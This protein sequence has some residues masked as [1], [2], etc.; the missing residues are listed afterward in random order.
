MRPAD[1]ARLSWVLAEAGA[2]LAR[3]TA[4]DPQAPRPAWRRMGGLLR[5]GGA[6]R[7]EWR[8]GGWLRWGGWRIRRRHCRR[9]VAALDRIEPPGFAIDRPH[10]QPCGQRRNVDGAVERIRGAGG[11]PLNLG[12][13]GRRSRRR[14]S[15]AGANVGL[16]GGNIVSTRY[17][18]AGAFGVERGRRDVDPAV[19]DVEGNLRGLDRQHA[20]RQRRLDDLAQLDVIG[21]LP[22]VGGADRNLE[23]A[24][25]E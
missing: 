17:D 6:V 24:R 22:P 8:G 23:G 21:G 2:E 13:A 18:G 11:E 12:A 14:R 7:A 4:A 16:V 3:R 25:I 19:P 20:G 10:R 1:A 5:G 15:Q 9:R